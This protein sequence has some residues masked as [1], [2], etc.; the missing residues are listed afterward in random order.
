MTQVSTFARFGGPL[1]FRRIAVFKDT[2][3]TV[4]RCDVLSSSCVRDVW[5]KQE[6]YTFICIHTRTACFENTASLLPGMDFPNSR[7]S[8]TDGLRKPGGSVLGSAAGTFLS[9][10]FSSRSAGARVFFTLTFSPP[11]TQ[12]SVAVQRGFR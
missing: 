10:R 3:S 4:G 1:V 11:E 12:H 8:F 7:Y 9:S 6:M 2:A 5:D